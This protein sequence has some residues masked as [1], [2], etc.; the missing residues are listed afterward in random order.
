MRL[1]AGS[2][3]ADVV[4][5]EGAEAIMGYTEEEVLGTQVAV[6]LGLGLAPTTVMLFACGPGLVTAALVMALG[7]HRRGR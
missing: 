7:W 3:P 2:D 1:P 5:N 6:V 4:Q